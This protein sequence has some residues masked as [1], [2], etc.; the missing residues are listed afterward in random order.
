MLFKDDGMVELSYIL[1]IWCIIFGR[2]VGEMVLIK[3]LGN[4]LIRNLKI[5]LRLVNKDLIDL[6][7]VFF[8]FRVFCLMLDKIYFLEMDYL[9]FVFECLVRFFFLYLFW[10]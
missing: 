6:F 7:V 9:Y 3:L 4:F 8:I 10:E 5:F 1:V 2:R